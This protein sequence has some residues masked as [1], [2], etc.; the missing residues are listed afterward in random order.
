VAV[1]AITWAVLEKWL[2]VPNEPN[3]PFVFN[4]VQ[5]RTTMGFGSPRTGLKFKKGRASQREPALAALSGAS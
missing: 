2:I 3:S 4:V 1:K 5:E